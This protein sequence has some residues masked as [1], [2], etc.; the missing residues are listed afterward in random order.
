MAQIHSETELRD[1]LPEHVLWS[2]EDPMGYKSLRDGLLDEL[3]PQTFYQ[4]LIADKLVNLEWELFRYEG[5]V[6]DFLK[7]KTRAIAANT[8]D[9]GKIASDKYSD[10]SKASE[11]MATALFNPRAKGKEKALQKLRLLGISLG[12]ITA[13]AYAEYIEFFN[14]LEYRKIEIETRRRNMRKD[15]DRLKPSRAEPVEEAEVLS[16]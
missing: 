12:E 11:A 16:E 8:L 15:Y 3:C 10:N 6:A 2:D 14:L 1:F 13:V 9:T 5:L 4:R 7:T